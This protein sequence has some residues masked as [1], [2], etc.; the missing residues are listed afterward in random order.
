MD[1]GDFSFSAD[2]FLKSY[3]V[4]K[5][6]CVMNFVELSGKGAKYQVNL[7]DANIH[8]GQ[9]EALD[10]SVV[11]KHFAGS[12]G[13]PA[14]LFGA[15]FHVVKKGGVEFG[16]SKSKVLEIFAAVKKVYGPAITAADAAK[17]SDPTPN[18][19]IKIACAQMFLDE[20][21]G[22]CAAFEGKPRTPPTPVKDPKIPGVHPQTIKK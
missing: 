11:H 4:S 6:D 22:K 8:I 2:T 15:D 13:C 3:R 16:E 14:P 7:C 1:Q 18:S 9:H 19:E 17:I 20:Y 5:S 10:S 21:L 12:S